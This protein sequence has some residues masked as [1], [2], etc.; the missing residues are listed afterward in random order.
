MCKV[1]L[2]YT[3]ILLKCL[4]GCGSAAGESLDLLNLEHVIGSVA[5]DNTILLVVDDPANSK[6]VVKILEDLLTGQ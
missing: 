6:E 3:S 1:C 4:S 5:G 2:L